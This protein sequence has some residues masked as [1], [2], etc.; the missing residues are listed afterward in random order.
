MSTTP[1]TDAEAYDIDVV[2]DAYTKM[3]KYP[4]AD[5]V[6]ATFARQLEAELDDKESELIAKE[7]ECIL[8]SLWH[9]ENKE[10]LEQLRT[11][12]TSALAREAGLR[13]ALEF[14]LL[15]ANTIDLSP[16][17]GGSC[18]VATDADNGLQSLIAQLKQALSSNPPP[19][20]SARPLPY[21]HQKSKTTI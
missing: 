10:E 18:M 12:L 4:S 19:P 17:D 20:Q 9:D 5:H 2:G 15:Q 3:D 16:C 21:S 14:A 8:W 7:E 6:P 1:R 11:E 13:A